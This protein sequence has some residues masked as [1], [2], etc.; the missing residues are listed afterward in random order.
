MRNM[1]Q[2]GSARR[3]RYFW[4]GK[5]IVICLATVAV[6]V[7]GGFW[8][9]SASGESDSSSLAVSAVPRI[10][11]GFTD[12]GSGFAYKLGACADGECT[13]DVY[14]YRRCSGVLEVGANIL[15]QGK[16]IDVRTNDDTYQDLP[17]GTVVTTHFGMTQYRD[18]DTELSVDAIECRL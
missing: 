8:I 6:A 15:R 13:V 11:A 14:P 17:A 10:P 16:V 1:L 12:L 18:A 7:V 3:R 2:P 5:G 4:E 9:T